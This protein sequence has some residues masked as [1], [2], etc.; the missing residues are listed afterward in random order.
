MVQQAAVVAGKI[1][2]P[3]RDVAPFLLHQRNLSPHRTADPLNTNTSPSHPPTS[4]SSL[5]NWRLS[6]EKEGRPA[7][8]TVGEGA[9]RP[10]KGGR[11]GPR[12]ARGE[13]PERVGAKG[14]AV[15][16]KTAPRLS[17]ASEFS[18]PRRQ[19]V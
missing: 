10:I 3:T 12:E 13:N 7:G 14:P 19:P 17:C 15:A 4:S 18:R 1:R 5:P 8:T 2:W 9:R 11:R 6:G 16:R